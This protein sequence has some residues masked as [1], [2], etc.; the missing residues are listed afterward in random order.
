MIPPHGREKPIR[1]L[2]RVDWITSPPSLTKQNRP[3]IPVLR[4]MQARQS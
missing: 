4:L 1:F 3:P 2:R